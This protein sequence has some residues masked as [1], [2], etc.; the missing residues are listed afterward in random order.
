MKEPLTPEQKDAIL[1]FEAAINPPNP[2]SSAQIHSI[3][4][5]TD[6]VE[7]FVYVPSN[8]FFELLEALK[9]FLEP[10]IGEARVIRLQDAFDA[11]GKSLPKE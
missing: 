3:K 11:L 7:E 5:G 10:R 6:T 9:D 2:W 1:S 8:E 4:N